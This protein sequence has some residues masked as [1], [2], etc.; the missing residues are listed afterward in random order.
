M[1]AS[2]QALFLS[3]QNAITK[4]CAASERFDQTIELRLPHAIKA[5]NRAR[6]FPYQIAGANF[7]TKASGHLA[8]LKAFVTIEIDALADH[9]T[10]EPIPFGTL[11]CELQFPSALALHF[12]KTLKLS[13]DIALVC[14]IDHRYF[15]P[16]PA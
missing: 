14:Q 2:L 3:W 8:E 10:S 11:A 13:L 12:A 5:V 6:V 9:D 16:P 4:Q 1:A 7:G 15:A